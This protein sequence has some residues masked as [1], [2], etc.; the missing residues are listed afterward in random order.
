MF[1]NRFIQENGCVERFGKDYLE[2]RKKVPMFIPRL[3][4]NKS[5]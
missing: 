2:Y 1:Y 4:K 5:K 3:I